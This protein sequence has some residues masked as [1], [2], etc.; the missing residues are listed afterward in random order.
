M[1]NRGPFLRHSNRISKL[2]DLVSSK[3]EVAND[4]N[5]NIK[6]FVT[7]NKKEEK[8]IGIQLFF[9]ECVTPELVYCTTGALCMR[10]L[11]FHSPK[12]ESKVE[13]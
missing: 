4:E 6:I 2:T 5:T 8:K 3:A 10:A 9:T 12:T 7:Q 11:S 13:S 1:I